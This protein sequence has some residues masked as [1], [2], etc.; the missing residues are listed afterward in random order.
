MIPTQCAA[1]TRTAWVALGLVAFVPLARS[2]PPFA[3]DDPEPADFRHWEFYLAS[4]YEHGGDGAA[5]T[6]P[7]IELNYGAA[8]NLMLHAIVPMAFDAPAGGP[9]EYGIGDI[10]LG[11]KYR[12]VGET[13]DRPQIG[14]FPLVELPAGDSAR[15][16]GSGHTEVFLPVWLQKSFGPWTTYGGGGYW[17]NP[18]AGNRDWWFT[19]WLLQR[20]VRDNLAVGAEIFHE[21]AQAVGGSSDTNANLGIVWDLDKT[22]HILASVGHTLQGPD[23]YQ[24]Y[25]AFQLTFGP[26]E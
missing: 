23:G 18:G 13:D 15:G 16:L 11:A 5:G 21:T 1:L 17:R 25:L 26:G 6:L 4:Q 9:R 24:A 2:G 14:V 12:F 19:G 3:T 8:P 22:R 20:Q 10:E 7:H